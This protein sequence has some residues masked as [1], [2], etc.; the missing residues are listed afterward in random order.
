MSNKYFVKF[1]PSLNAFF[2]K[3]YS[4]SYCI[5]NNIIEHNHIL[6]YKQF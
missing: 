5:H 1:T 2:I 6:I 3:E 4:T